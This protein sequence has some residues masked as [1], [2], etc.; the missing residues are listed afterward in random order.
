ML[1]HIDELFQRPLAS[2]YKYPET[3][4]DVLLSP[5]SPQRHPYTVYVDSVHLGLF[6]TM[7]VCCVINFNKI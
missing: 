7:E 1:Y 2:Q 4:I 6:S 5:D 3:P